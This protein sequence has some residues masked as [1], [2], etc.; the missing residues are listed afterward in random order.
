MLFQSADPKFY[1]PDRK[2]AKI[3]P[4]SETGF[5]TMPYKVNYFYLFLGPTTFYVLNSENQTMCTYNLISC[6]M[7]KCKRVQPIDIVNN[8]L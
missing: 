4:K 8:N 2:C 1:G 3:S 5:T 6:N 7:L